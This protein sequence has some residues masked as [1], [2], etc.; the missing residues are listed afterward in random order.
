MEVYTVRWLPVTTIASEAIIIWD[1]NS[2]SARRTHWNGTGLDIAHLSAERHSNLLVLNELRVLLSSIVTDQI[3]VF[4][5]GLP[6]P[7]DTWVQET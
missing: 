4:Q 6:R 5:F 3:L 2:P 7:V 1:K